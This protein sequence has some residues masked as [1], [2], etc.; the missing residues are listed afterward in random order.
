MNVSFFICFKMN[1]WFQ[2]FIIDFCLIIYKGI[3]YKNIV[4]IK[5]T[6]VLKTFVN[7]LFKNILVKIAIKATPDF[8]FYHLNIHLFLCKF[9]G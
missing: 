4:N 3:K 2:T 1:L 9:A 8:L 5:K 7:L 6:I